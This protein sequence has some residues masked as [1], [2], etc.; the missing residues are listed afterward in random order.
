M[1]KQ[2]LYYGR[3]EPSVVV[4]GIVSPLGANKDVVQK[5]LSTRLAERG[6]QTHLIKIM[7]LLTKR[8]TNPLLTG[9]RNN[10]WYSAAQTEGN[11]FRKR[12]EAYDAMAGLAIEHIHRAR[13]EQRG[14][15]AFVVSSLKRP[16][17]VELLR[18]VYGKSFVLLAVHDTDAAMIKGLAERLAKAKHQGFNENDGVDAKSLI[19][20]DASEDDDPFGQR[21]AKTYP[22]ADAFID[23][24]C[25]TTAKRET[26]RI[27]DMMFTPCF[28]SPS[29]DE[30]AMMHAYAAGLRSADLSRQVGAALVSSRGDVLATGTNDVPRAGGGIYWE[31]DPEDTRDFQLGADISKER[32]LRIV[33]ELLPQFREEKD[34]DVERLLKRTQVLALGEFGRTVHAE[35]DAILCA[36][37]NRILVHGTSIYTTTF[38]CHNCVKHIIG[39]GIARVVFIMPYEKSLAYELHDDAVVREGLDPNPNKV[40][41]RR[42]VGVA[43]RRYADFFAAEKDERREDA[44]L[45][46]K[47]H[48]RVDAKQYGALEEE[49]AARMVEVKHPKVRLRRAGSRPSARASRRRAGAA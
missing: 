9:P 22:L 34:S 17:E 38:P 7:D 37:R 39:A 16:E 13:S 20:R 26:E 6:Y 32:R 5:H 40:I 33:R 46:L 30:H 42:F 23:A 11:N 31:G 25:S 3:S 43:P 8:L 15:I 36:S 44:K 4:V 21:V 18:T 19:V 47:D 28:K 27:L 10:N 12:Y 48:F 41:L 49:I 1:P 29:R 24:S 14:P 2:S 35:M 45:K